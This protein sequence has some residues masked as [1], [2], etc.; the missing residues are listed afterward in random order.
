M[1]PNFGSLSFGVLASLKQ[2]PNLFMKKNN[3]YLSFICC[4]E[5]Q[6]ITSAMK[7]K[8]VLHQK[9][10]THSY[11]QIYKSTKKKSI[12]DLHFAS[13]KNLPHSISW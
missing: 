9:K 4:R 12:T 5:T 10:G 11:L 8:Y 3:L 13:S 7:L 1:Q 6:K 2:D